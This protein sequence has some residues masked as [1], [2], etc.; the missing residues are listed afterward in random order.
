ME[1]PA[2]VNGVAPTSGIH[3]LLDIV[4]DEQDPERVVLSLEVTPSVHQPFGILHGGVSALLA[5]S[6]ASFGAQLSAPPG[7]TVVGVEINANHLRAM[8]QGTLTATATPVRRG[9]RIHVWNIDLTDEQDRM[10]CTSRC[11]IMVIPL[12]EE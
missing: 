6:A 7:H 9:R 1:E 3:E 11:T 10:I 2:W 8:R 4:L 12:S 5:E